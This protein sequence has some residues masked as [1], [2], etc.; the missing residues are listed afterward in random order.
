MDANAEPALSPEAAGCRLAITSAA[1][2]DWE[3]WRGRGPKGPLGHPVRGSEDTA[4]PG[5]ALDPL[6]LLSTP[7]FGANDSTPHHTSV[8]S[9]RSKVL[10][11]SSFVAILAH[12][13][14]FKE[15]L[16][17]KKPL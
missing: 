4:E 12:F 3:P 13:P 9:L 5:M 16:F 10:T 11:K 7:G 2:L 1:L 15:S 17:T 14:Y 6:P 8:Y